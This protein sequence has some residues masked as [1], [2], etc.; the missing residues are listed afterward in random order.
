MTTI[1]KNEF[2]SFLE[3]ESKIEEYTNKSLAFVGIDNDQVYKFD[4]AS[5]ELQIELDR[6]VDA[7]CKSYNVT[8]SDFISQ[9][10]EYIKTIS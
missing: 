1:D 7:V 4:K 9:L 2:K 5:S 10:D 8:Y 3:K 6:Q